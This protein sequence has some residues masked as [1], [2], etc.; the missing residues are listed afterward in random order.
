MVLWVV[1][2]HQGHPEAS[3]VAGVARRA[4]ML[5]Y[6]VTEAYKGNKSK[7]EANVMQRLGTTS[8]LEVD[9]YFPALNLYIELDVLFHR[10]GTAHSFNC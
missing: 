6:D 5:K 1:R 8:V 4:G 10:T 2:R 3:G 7:F 9:L